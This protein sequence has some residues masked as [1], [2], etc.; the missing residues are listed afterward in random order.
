MTCDERLKSIRLENQFDSSKYNC[1]ADSAYRNAM[2]KLGL[3]Q[4]TKRDL[5]VIIFMPW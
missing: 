5:L 3:A 1:Y 4:Q 2:K